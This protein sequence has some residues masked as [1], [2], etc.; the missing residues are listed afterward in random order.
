MAAGERGLFASPA[1]EAALWSAAGA[2]AGEGALD[3]RALAAAI[4]ARSRRYT[5]ERQDMGA[6]SAQRRRLADLAARAVFFSVCDSPKLAVPIFELAG[7]AALP[8]TGPVRILDLGAGCGGTALGALDALSAGGVLR[9]GGLRAEILAVD[10]DREALSVARAALSAA[11]WRELSAVET[12]AAD[13]RRPGWCERRF[14]L[15][16]AGGL[17]NELAEDDAASVLRRAMASLSPGGAVVIVEP[18]L[19]ETSRALHR[20]RD[21]AI[22]EGHSVFA[23]CTRDRAPCP[24]LADARDWCHEDRPIRLPPRTRQLAGAT[25]LRQHGA[26]FSYLV[27][28]REPLSLAGRATEPGSREARV[29]SRVRKQKGQS[30]CFVCSDEGRVRLRRLGRERSDANRGLDRARR[31]DVLI[32]PASALATGRVDRT[33]EV[34]SIDPAGEPDPGTGTF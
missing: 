17:V 32:V 29:V 2:V 11:P 8:A 6:P 27:L 14:D 16:L 19:R 33:D 23:P 12:L 13:A 15:A 31:G 22:A 10:R 26:K 18:A 30:E 7:R 28:R 25:G 3:R 20:L 4:R 21:A 9:R 34:A 5:S 1:V 24:A